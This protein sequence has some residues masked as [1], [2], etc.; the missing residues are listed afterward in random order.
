MSVGFLV[1]RAT[2]LASLNAATAVVRPVLWC[3]DWIPGLSS[4]IEVIVMIYF[5]ACFRLLLLFD[6]AV[7]V[8]L[9]TLC[10]VRHPSGRALSIVNSCD[11]DFMPI[12]QFVDA[13]P[14]PA[15]Y[16]AHYSEAA[17]ISLAN[18]ARLVYEDRRLI[19]YELEQ[20]GFDPESVKLV[21]YRNTCGY[22]ALK[23]RTI[24]VAFRGTDPLNL[25]SL[26]TG[27]SKK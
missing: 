4:V 24:V 2:L 9:R 5:F 15:R 26:Y 22:V 19:Q 10:Q 21:S 1:A 8:M 16:P 6:R 12:A 11:P 27:N 17:A 20:S 23:D 14:L 13:E 7:R 3:I 25:M 18:H